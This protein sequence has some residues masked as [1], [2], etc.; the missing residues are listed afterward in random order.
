[1]I[2]MSGPN[3][4]EAFKKKCCHVNHDSDTGTDNG[5]D[6]WDAASDTGTDNGSDTD[7][8]EP[9]YTHSGCYTRKDQ[10]GE[11]S[12]LSLGTLA[13]SINAFGGRRLGHHGG[14]DHDSD[15]LSD[16]GDYDHSKGR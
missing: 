1:M 15:G 4:V 7:Y 12:S 9:H 8:D 6:T 16:S 10:D 11:K 5:S 14:G 2:E 13:K 3:I